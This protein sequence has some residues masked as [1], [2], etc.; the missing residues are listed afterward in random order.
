MALLFVPLLRAQ[1]TSGVRADGAQRTADLQDLT[2][3]ASTVAPSR[4]AEPV[5]EEF[6]VITDLPKRLSPF[7][8]YAIGQTGLF[9]ATNPNLIPTGGGGDGYYYARATAGMRPHLHKGLYLDANVTQ[10]I[11]QYFQYSSLNFTRF[12]AAA[13]FDYVSKELGGA[14]ASVR[15]AYSRFLDG[16]ALDEFYVTNDLDLSL[17]VPLPLSQTHSL[18]AFALTSLALDTQPAVARRN[19]YQLVTAWRW[20]IAPPLTLQSYYSLALFQYPNNGPRLDVTNTVGS[21]LIVSI[22]RYAQVSLSADYSINSSTNSSFNYS[23][24]TLGGLATLTFLF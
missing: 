18:Q 15:Y 4:A 2:S 14:M 17:S 12:R 5:D 13:G 1:Q 23:N 21:S 22:T 11:F 7:A 20:Q 16:R 6:G 3:A 19:L 9:Y 8:A 24:F 10:D